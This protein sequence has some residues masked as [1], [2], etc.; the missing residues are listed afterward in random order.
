METLRYNSFL[1]KKDRMIHVAL[2]YM[3]ESKCY[4][5]TIGEDQKE[6]DGYFGTWTLVNE[7]SEKCK[8]AS[9]EEE[10]TCCTDYESKVYVILGNSTESVNGVQNIKTH[11]DGKMDGTLCFT[12]DPLPDDFVPA[13]SPA[14]IVSL[15]GQP[16]DM[17]AFAL[18][19]SRDSYNKIYLSSQKRT[20]LRRIHR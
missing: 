5:A 20:M 2:Y 13:L 18:H 4:T 8:D 16:S 12:A 9:F 17:Q 1:I 7:L 19:L 15:E 3:T 11:D 6:S 10:V 14:Y